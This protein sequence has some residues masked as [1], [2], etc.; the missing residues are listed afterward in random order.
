MKNI[1]I[2]PSTDPCPIKDLGQYAKKLELAGADWLHCDIMDGKFVPK[3]TFDSIVFALLAKSTNM[4]LDVHLMV[5]DPTRYAKDFAKYG[6]HNITIHFESFSNKIL[7]I[8]ALQQIRDLGVKVGIS[9]KPGTPVTELDNILPYVDIVLVMSVEPGKSG[10]QFMKEALS[11]I[12]H[13]SKKRAEFDY[14][15]L[16]EVDGGVNTTNSSIIAVSGADVLVSGSAIY[17]SKSYKKV[18]DE[19]KGHKSLL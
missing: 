13:L 4:P 11:K 15:F 5:A 18:I 2:A 17:S 19:L 10:Q 8:N 3:R 9:I 14:K 12:S 1:L 16:I 7:L 6:A